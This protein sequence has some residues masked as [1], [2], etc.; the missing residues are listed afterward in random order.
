MDNKILDKI[1]IFCKYQKDF[2]PK[3]TTGKKTTEFI[4]GYITA[5]T[6]ILYLIDYE[7]KCS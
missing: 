3:E 2:F 5:I 4:A 1:E 6:D 7:K